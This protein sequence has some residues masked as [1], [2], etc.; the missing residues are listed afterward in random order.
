[1]QL[2]ERTRCFIENKPICYEKR[3]IE[4][5]KTCASNYEKNF[6]RKSL[7]EQNKSNAR[8]K[9]TAKSVTSGGSESIVDDPG[10]HTNIGA[11]VS[12][13]S[14]HVVSGITRVFMDFLQAGGKHAEKLEA[15]GAVVTN[16]EFVQAASEALKIIYPYWDFLSNQLMLS[17][18]AI[19]EHRCG[20]DDIMEL[21]DAA[22][23]EI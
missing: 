8:K 13:S 5:I 9:I 22:K 12:P 19:D 11:N 15:S 21:A 14:F 16:V 2:S 6:Q 7:T 23:A 18:N 3:S 17:I 10:L 4:P 20:M 1:M